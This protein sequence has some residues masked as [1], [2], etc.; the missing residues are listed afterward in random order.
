MFNNQGQIN[1]NLF[2]PSTSL[3]CFIM[4]FNMVY[5]GVRV[6]IGF[7]YG[8]YKGMIRNLINQLV[9]VR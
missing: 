9:C 5:Y 3:Y 8:A 2:P 1:G 7:I 4:Y 6:A